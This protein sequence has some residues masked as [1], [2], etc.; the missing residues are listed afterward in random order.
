MATARLE[1][2]ANA[3]LLVVGLG[4]GGLIVW[5]RVKPT[6]PTI[7]PRG[8]ADLPLPTEPVSIGGA[9]SRGELTAPVI[10]MEWSDF[11]CPY[12]AKAATNLVPELERPYVQ[13]GKVRIVFKHLPLKIHAHAQ[14]AAEVAECAAGQGRFWAFHDWAFRNQGRLDLPQ[15]QTQAGALGIQMATLDACMK[16]GAAIARVKLDLDQ[17]SRYQITGTP[18][19]FV[20]VAQPND[21][22]RVTERFSGTRPLADVQ[23]ML[24]TAIRNS[25]KVTDK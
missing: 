16:D 9:P 15:L 3:V 10:L 8:R 17:A 24:D 1:W 11:E 22:V 6:G 21:T 4:V 18:T 5:D 14:K 19:W 7:P 2:W 25:A 23:R 12:C 13:S 20:G